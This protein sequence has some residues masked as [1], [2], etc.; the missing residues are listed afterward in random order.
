MSRA[1]FLCLILFF[2]SFALAQNPNPQNSFAAQPSSSTVQVVYV[3]EG[4]TIVTY[5]VN[6][7]TLYATQVGTSLT[8]NASS[9]YFLYPSPNDH[10][11]Y[12]VAYDASSNKHLWVYDTDISGV[13]QVPA[14][15]EIDARGFDGLQINPKIN[16]LYA[17]Y[18]AP[19]GLYN[20][21]YT[22]QRYVIDPS[23]GKISQPQVEG[24]YILPNGAEGT[25]GCYLSIM[26]FTPTGNNLFD[27]IG[28]SYHGGNSATYNERTL[29]LK[30]GA[31]GPDVQ[32]YSWNNATEGG[33]Y[34]QFVRN[35][36][37]D[38][39]TPNN[40]DPGVNSV[41]IYPVQP[42]TN[43]PLVQCTATMLEACGYAGGVAHPSGKY[44]FMA[45]SQ[46]AT[47]IDKVELS[48]KKIVDTSHYIPNN[49]S[50][51]SPDGTLV[52]GVSYS[53]PGYYIE[54]YGFNVATSDVTTSGGI[55]GIPS[56]NDFFVV[57]E[58]Y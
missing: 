49:V 3:V 33:E 39:V 6:Q 35:H 19:S 42:N 2:A 50:Q 30:T 29:N 15:Q 44:V 34:V 38:F 37:F 22:I 14:V 31:L 48:A 52:Y 26:G 47:Q 18:E 12:V 21:A 41:N 51:F 5:N 4:T 7:Q 45:I 11:L 24:T 1:A 36:M 8:V 54:I 25:E 20:T 9:V 43:T 17:V 57:A 46:G 32:I 16:F 40:Y 13:P 58:R 23:A 10:F 56:I 55:I 28:C 53:N 27:E